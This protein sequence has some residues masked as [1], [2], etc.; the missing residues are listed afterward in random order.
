MQDP[1]FARLLAALDQAPTA[2]LSI[3]D[4]A[5][6]AI[7]RARISAAQRHLDGIIQESAYL[8]F[9]G[10]LALAGGRDRGQHL[11]ASA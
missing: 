9:A 11:A 6:L 1:V 8:A 2:P 4:D 7:A 3:V 5:D 10:R